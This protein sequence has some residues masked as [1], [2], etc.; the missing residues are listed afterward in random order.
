MLP[1]YIPSFMDI[2]YRNVSVSLIIQIIV[3]RLICWYL[4]TQLR[5]RW[6]DRSARYRYQLLI[7]MELDINVARI[8]QFL[9]IIFS[10]NYGMLKVSKPSIFG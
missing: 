9:V 6:A 2:G 10:L 1:N 3:D 8:F 4:K 7:E 5:I